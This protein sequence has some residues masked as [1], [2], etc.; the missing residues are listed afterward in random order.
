MPPKLDP[1]FG[2]APLQLAK[3][4]S[5][6]LPFGLSLCSGCPRWPSHLFSHASRLSPPPMAPGRERGCFLGKENPWEAEILKASHGFPFKEDRA[7]VKKQRRCHQIPELT[8]R[9][10][11]PQG[12]SSGFPEDLVQ[13]PLTG[14]VGLFF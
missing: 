3:E 11:P 14:V 2:D 8:R 6:P 10:P 4:P 12:Q 9:F 1:E 5:A 13:G 7:V